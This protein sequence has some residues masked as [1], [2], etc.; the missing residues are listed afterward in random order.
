MSSVLRQRSKLSLRAYEV[1]PRTSQESP[2]KFS[3][4]LL[5]PSIAYHPACYDTR[6]WRHFLKTSA[7]TCRLLMKLQTAYGQD[8]RTMKTCHRSILLGP[9]SVRPLDCQEVSL[10][11]DDSS[12]PTTST[13]PS[14]QKARPVNIH[15]PA[16]HHIYDRT[17]LLVNSICGIG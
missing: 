8:R 11:E 13:F 4:L 2:S 5:L 16:H 6:H 12:L 10:R 1:R 9:S 15:N 14:R 3:P 7:N 17:A